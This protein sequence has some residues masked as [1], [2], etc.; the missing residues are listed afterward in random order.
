MR[1]FFT[2]ILPLILPTGLYVLWAVSV[3]RA[4][5]AG[6]PALWRDL[7]WIW[8]AVAGAILVAVVLVAVVQVGGV[9]GGK[10]VP[11]HVEKGVVVPGHFVPETKR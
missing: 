7:P 3:G 2:I 6:M 1:V 11:P 5:A 10:Y 9:Q 4:E 8:L